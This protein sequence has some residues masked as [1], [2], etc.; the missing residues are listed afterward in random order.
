MGET[1]Y[2]GMQLLRL[3]SVPK[4]ATAPD[5]FSETRRGRRLSCTATVALPDFLALFLCHPDSIPPFFLVSS[6]SHLFFFA[7]LIYLVDVYAL[8]FP[9]LHT[10][11]TTAD[12][13]ALTNYTRRSYEAIYL[14]PYLRIR[15]YESIAYNV[16]Q[17]YIV[18]FAFSQAQK[19]I[20]KYSMIR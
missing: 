3:S 11:S 6:S 17:K 12:W 9:N 15:Y 1:N 20:Y 19:L 10:N 5:Q 16:S 13:S 4:T 2:R 7:P 8:E 18:N 14:F